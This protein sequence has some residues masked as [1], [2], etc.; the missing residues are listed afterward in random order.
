MQI[1][2]QSNIITCIE[3]EH[4]ADMGLPTITKGLKALQAKDK[5]QSEGSEEIH[6]GY[7]SEPIVVGNFFSVEMEFNATFKMD[8]HRKLKQIAVF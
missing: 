5:A 8:G 3:P 7:C 1:E 6:G 2:L 4:P